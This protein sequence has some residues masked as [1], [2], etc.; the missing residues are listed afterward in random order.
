MV[1][2]RMLN[3]ASWY[4]AASTVALTLLGLWLWPHLAIAIFAGGLL[5]TS[6]F[7]A[8]RYLL[9]RALQA[10]KRKLAYGIAL[11]SKFAVVLGV[12]AL[13]VLYFEIDPMGMAIGMSSLFFGIG[14]ATA[15]GAFDTESEQPAHNPIES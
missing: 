13:L 2:P 3:R 11:S 8:M 7:V 9:V 15:H 5:M 10:K 14:L 12:M 4:Q 6:N 1:S